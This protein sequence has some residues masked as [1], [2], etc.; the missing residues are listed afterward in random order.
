MRT[1]D[2]KMLTSL[3]KSGGTTRQMTKVQPGKHSR[4][5]F[6]NRGSLQYEFGDQGGL[7]VSIRD[8]D[9]SVIFLQN[10]ADRGK[11]WCKHDFDERIRPGALISDLRSTSQKPL[12]FVRFSAKFVGYQLDLSNV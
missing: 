1:F 9:F 11:I 2:P 12:L 10:S 4:R 5:N 3:L 8:G 6:L 7:I